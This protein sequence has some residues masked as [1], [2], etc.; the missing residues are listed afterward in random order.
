MKFAADLRRIPNFC[1]FIALL[2]ERHY[3]RPLLFNPVLILIS[4]SF[5]FR[6]PNPIYAKYDLMVNEILDLLI[7]AHR[8]ANWEKDSHCSRDQGG[9]PLKWEVHFFCYKKRSFLQQKKW[10]PDF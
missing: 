2:S 10:L 5:Y 6:S 1:I 7:A 3:K 8:Q 9:H 4:K